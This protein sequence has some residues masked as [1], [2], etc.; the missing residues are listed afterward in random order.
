[1][2]G[3]PIVDISSGCCAGITLR[4]L[5]DMILISVHIL[6]AIGLAKDVDDKESSSALISRYN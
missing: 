1:M 4:S 5:R 2:K 3:T 6:V